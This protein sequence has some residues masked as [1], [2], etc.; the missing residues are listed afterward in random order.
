MRNDAWKIQHTSSVRASTLV[1]RIPFC[2]RS[3]R[4]SSLWIFVD[5]SPLSTSPSYAELNKVYYIYLNAGVIGLLQH[6]TRCKNS[7]SVTRTDKR[8]APRL[9]LLPC[10]RYDTRIACHTGRRC[11]CRVRCACAKRNKT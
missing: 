8:L 4:F 1:A 5:T 7:H 2:S 11:L 6:S 10:A 9:L 3:V